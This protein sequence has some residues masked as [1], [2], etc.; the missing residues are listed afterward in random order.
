ML[1]KVIPDKRKSYG[2]ALSKWE[3]LEAM[4]DKPTSDRP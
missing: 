1:A 3:L 2:K 4:E